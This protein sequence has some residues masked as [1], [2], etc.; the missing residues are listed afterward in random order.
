MGDWTA[1]LK[2]YHYA[3][4]EKYGTDAALEIYERTCK[5]DDRIKSFTN[6]VLKAFELE[7]NDAETIGAWWDLWH[8]S[9]GR[10]VLYLNGLKKSIELKSLSVR[11]KQSPKISAVGP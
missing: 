2:A 10:K 7:G 1:W 8:N 6:A 4:R 11:L 5:M 9:M 3:I